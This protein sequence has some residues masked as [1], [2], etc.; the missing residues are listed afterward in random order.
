MIKQLFFPR[1]I[2]AIVVLVFHF[3]ANYPDHSPLTRTFLFRLFNTGDLAVIFFFIL[4]GFILSYV[5]FNK[6]KELNLKQFYA[7]RFARIYP[8][9]LLSILLYLLIGL[10]YGK[11]YYIHSNTLILN[12]LMVQGW[13]PNSIGLLNF[14][15]WSVSVEI[16]FY[17]LFPFLL[18]GINYLNINALSLILLGVGVWSGYHFV[19]IP[20]SKIVDIPA[21][22]KYL[23]V[24]IIGVIAGIVFRK[25]PNPFPK[26]R[27]KNY[28]FH[29]TILAIALL[30]ILYVYGIYKY[31]LNSVDNSVAV[32]IFTLLIVVLAWD[33]SFLSRIL[34]NQF[35]LILGEISYGIYILQFPVRFWF[36]KLCEIFGYGQSSTI[37]SYLF[38]PFLIGFAYVSFILI[39]EPARHMAKRYFVR[40][41]LRIKKAEE[42]DGL[43]TV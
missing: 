11:D 39:E 30:V 4:S 7:F 41:A 12:I 18:K 40:Q 25:L 32:L 19:V 14:A 5:Y 24:F 23:P 36:G 43:V 21:V 35:L 2:A 15:A 38:V 31:N 20:V 9:Y 37:V 16:F 8:A 28:I 42:G 6:I 13:I 3:F 10:V 33:T 17:L 27:Y 1:F 34:S 29:T 26:F 22:F